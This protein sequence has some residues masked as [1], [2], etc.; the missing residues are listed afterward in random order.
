MAHPISDRTASARKALLRREATARREALDGRAARSAAICQLVQGLPAYQ[1][2]AA[3]HCFLPIRSEVDTRPLVV[4]ALAAGKAVAVPVVGADGVLTHS[5]LDALTAEA[6]ASGAHGTLQPRHLQ[7]AYVG[8]WT[9]TIVPLLAFDRA[10]YR[11]GYGK[12]YYDQFLAHVNG[13]TVGVAFAC[14]AWPGLPHEPHDIPL[15]LVVTE[16]ELISPRRCQ[17]APREP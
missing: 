11:L 5:W 3:L 9:L 10:G 7:P 13:L 6:L 4:A 16:T 8:E 17:P 15:A 1:A 2:A 14:Q 12:G